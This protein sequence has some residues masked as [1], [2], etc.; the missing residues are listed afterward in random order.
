MFAKSMGII[1]RNS[2][3][4]LEILVICHTA[5]GYKLAGGTIEQNETPEKACLREIGEET[6][7]FDVVITKKLI[8]SKI[9]LKDDE[10][11]VKASSYLFSRPND[12]SFNWAKLPKG[13]RV[14]KE[15][16]LDEYSQVVFTE[17]ESLNSKDISYQLMGFILNENLTKD[18]KRFTYHLTVNENVK[19]QKCIINDGFKYEIKW[20]K[21]KI[22]IDYLNKKP[23]FKR[24]YTTSEMK[25]ITNYILSL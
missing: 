19:T 5:D 10:Y 16:S 12:I 25:T 21:A 20:V 18:A 3:E 17:Y 14:T 24:I 8:E 15:K 7:I 4:N 9:P 2:G 22:F 13:V 11:Y 1:T 6:E 23:W